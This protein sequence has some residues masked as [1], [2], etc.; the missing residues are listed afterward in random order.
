MKGGKRGKIMIMIWK[1]NLKRKK[2]EVLK[3]KEG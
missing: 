2:V 1:G 3:K